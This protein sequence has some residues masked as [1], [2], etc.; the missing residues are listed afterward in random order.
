MELKLENKNIDILH[1]KNGLIPTIIQDNQS[2][3]IY[4]LGYMNKL[5]LLKSLE[6]KYVWFWSRTRKKLWLK[7]ETSGNMLKII[8]VHADCDYDTILIKVNLEGK[9]VCH[10]GNLTC[11]D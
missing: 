9:N 11:F 1:F 2:L 10:T 6:T 3:I 4:M 5:S 7:G 8:S